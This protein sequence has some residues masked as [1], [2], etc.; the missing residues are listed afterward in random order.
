M[1]NFSLEPKNGD[2]AS[3]VDKKGTYDCLKLQQEIQQA[4]LKSEAKSLEL[5][6]I[7]MQ[8]EQRFAKQKK[9]HQK[10][11]VK[12]PKDKISVNLDNQAINEEGTILNTYVNKVSQSP[13]AKSGAR[14]GTTSDP[15]PI[16]SVKIIVMVITFLA[17]LVIF[18]EIDIK[19][20]PFLVFL[21]TVLAISSRRKNKRKGK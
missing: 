13:V 1:S 18:I 4:T 17:L 12:A 19:F 7:E 6:K 11:M 21:F 16:G 15:D 3:L 10:S 20:I 5:E 9:A 8:N 2:Y 14:V